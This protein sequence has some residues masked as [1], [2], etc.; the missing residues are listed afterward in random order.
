MITH[1]NGHAATAE[2][3]APL[4]FA[5]FAHFTAMQLRSGAVR[6]LDLHVARLDAASKELFGVPVGA[7]RVRHELHHALED[8]APDAS[9]TVV[10]GGSEFA[11]QADTLTTLVRV[12][13]PARAPRGPLRLDLIRHERHLAHIKHVGEIA[14][15][16]LL[17]VAQRRGFDD[18]AF[19]DAAGRLSEATIWNLAFWDGTEVVWPQARLLP[20]VTMQIV[21]RQLAEQGVPQ[22]VEEVRPDA[23]YA[24]VLLN[25]WSPAVPVASLGEAALPSADVLV[26]L[27]RAAY[28]AEPAVAP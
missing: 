20:G 23:G 1:I 9:V 2:E 24:A 17:H 22:R 26:D 3:L 19:V 8:A 7:E 27:F 13:P 16:Q 14:K 12:T 25:S 4:A 28:E 21:R 5:G 18:A 11:A 10:V 15:T 6:G